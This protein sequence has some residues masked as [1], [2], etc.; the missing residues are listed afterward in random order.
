[1]EKKYEAKVVNYGKRLMFEFLVPEPAAFH[2][3]AMTENAGDA[4]AGL[5]KPIDPRSPETVTAFSRQPIKSHADITESQLRLL[6]RDLRRRRGAA[7]GPAGDDQQ[8]L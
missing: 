6:G 2:L 7:T 8:V 4:A 3:Y 1:M 5:V